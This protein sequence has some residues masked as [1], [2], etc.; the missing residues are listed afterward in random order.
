[1]STRI[2]R[3]QDKAAGVESRASSRAGS[4]M[5]AR[6]GEGAAPCAIARPEAEA[7]G[8]ARAARS[9]GSPTNKFA[10]QSKVQQPARIGGE[11]GGAPVRR[12]RRASGIPDF[13]VASSRSRRRHSSVSVDLLHAWEAHAPAQF[14][15]MV[16]RAPARQLHDMPAELAANGR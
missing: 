15:A 13:Y 16:I 1:M 14:V 7:E 10:R 8:A 5:P 12:G 11:A 4:E 2:V 9:A 6:C 3:S